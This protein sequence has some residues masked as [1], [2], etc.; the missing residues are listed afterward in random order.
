MQIIHVFPRI[1]TEPQVRNSFLSH[2]RGLVMDD[3]SKQTKGLN[4]MT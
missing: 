3:R 4:H 1:A 2:I